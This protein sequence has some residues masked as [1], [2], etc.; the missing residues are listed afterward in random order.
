MERKYIKASGG[1]AHENLGSVII[2]CS[3]EPVARNRRAAPTLQPSNWDTTKTLAEL[4]FSR[5]FQPV[6][7]LVRRRVFGG[8]VSEVTEISFLAADHK[9]FRHRFQFLPPRANLFGL[10]LCNL[11]VVGGFGDDGKEVGKFLDDLVGGRNQKMRMR[12]VLRVED[13][14]SPGALANPLHQPVIA[15]AA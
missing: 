11:I 8:V 3:V 10:R 6:S 14:K 4:Q 15:G 1:Q 13:E 7:L 5:R 12:R 2:C 9:T